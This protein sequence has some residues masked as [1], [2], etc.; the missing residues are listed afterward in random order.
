MMFHIGMWCLSWNG[1]PETC[2]QISI[3]EPQF[4][5]SIPC[6]SF[7]PLKVLTASTFSSLKDLQLLL[8]LSHT[9]FLIHS[10]NTPDGFPWIEDKNTLEGRHSL[11]GRKKSSQLCCF[12]R[13]MQ[14]K[15][16]FPG[17]GDNTGNELWPVLKSVEPA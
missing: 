14:F 5:R 4:F 7:S 15:N 3:E 2:V 11:Q 17:Q 12:C 16:I 1:W 8:A 6:L 9:W 13:T 10:V